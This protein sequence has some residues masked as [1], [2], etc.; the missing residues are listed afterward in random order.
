MACPDGDELGSAQAVNAGVTGMAGATTRQRY[1]D[2]VVEHILDTG[3][4]DLSLVVLAD[5]AETSDRMLVY[6]FKTREALL[7]EAINNIRRRRRRTLAVS[8]ARIPRADIETDLRQV[9]EGLC[10]DE[11][12][13]ATRL[14]YDAAARGFRG[15]A[16]FRAFLE[17][18][19]RDS[20]D[21]AAQTARRLGADAS[22]AETFGT[23]FAA[24]SASLACDLQATNDRE[25]ID[26]TIAVAAKTLVAQLAPWPL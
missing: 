13:S 2:A 24:L 9:L 14:F 26:L 20:I 16:P 10:A 19:I 18:T 8:L 12:A 25:R 1:L 21:E 15:E 23:L 7:T 22:G 5:A 11:S 4:T 6:Y 17:G 3:R